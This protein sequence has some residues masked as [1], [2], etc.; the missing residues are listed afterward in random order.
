[1]Q[2]CACCPVWR[3]QSGF[4]EPVC[5]PCGQITGIRHG[6]VKVRILLRWALASAQ[7]ATSEPLAFSWLG[8]ARTCWSYCPEPPP[9]E[10]HPS[11]CH[12]HKVITSASDNSAWCWGTLWLEEPRSARQ[13]IHGPCIEHKELKCTCGT[14]HRE[15]KDHRSSSLLSWLSL[16]LHKGPSPLPLP[17]LTFCRVE[18]C[19][20]ADRSSAQLSERGA[21]LMWGSLLSV[22]ALRVT[23]WN[24][25]SCKEVHDIHETSHFYTTN[26]FGA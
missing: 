10:A 3:Q 26:C 7:Q 4:A 1:M 12:R 16:S 8:C 23:L 11:F 25:Y 6:G 19:H 24:S 14:S 5:P 18:L 22:Q 20:L 9:R 21:S 2:L 17:I 13:L 15:G